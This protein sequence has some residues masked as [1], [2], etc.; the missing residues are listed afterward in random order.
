MGT[1]RIPSRRQSFLSSALYGG[2]V[3]YGHNKPKI[4]QR[5]IKKLL[6]AWEPAIVAITAVMRTLVVVLD[7]PKRPQ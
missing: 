4:A 6:E 1:P 5:S 7:R 3:A 2:S